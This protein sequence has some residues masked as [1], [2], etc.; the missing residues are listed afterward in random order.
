MPN[1][2]H[3]TRGFEN[4]KTQMLYFNVSVYKSIIKLKKGVLPSQKEQKG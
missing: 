3:F 2:R 4:R 1:F